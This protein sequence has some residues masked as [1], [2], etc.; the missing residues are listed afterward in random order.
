MDVIS[1][2]YQFYPEIEP[3]EA[4]RI[5]LDGHHEMYWE[6]SGNPEGMPVVFLHGGPGAGASPSHRR[7]FDPNYYRIII[8][9]QRGSGRSRPF[10]EISNNSTQHLIADMERLRDHL[11]VEKWFVFGGSWGSSLALAY[12]INY[13]ERVAGFVLR[14]IFLCRNSELDW[15][16]NGMATVFPES[17]REFN[18]FLPEE[19]RGDVLASFHKRLLN[20]DPSV[21]APA[22]RAWARYEGACST[23]L[24][25][26]RSVPGLKPEPAALALARIEVHYF[27]NRMFMP[28]DYF[29]V[30]LDKIK[31]IPATIIQ[32]RYDMVCPT[33]TADE[34]SR[35]WPEAQ[36]Q[37]IPDAG[38]SAMEP[39]IRSALIAAMEHFKAGY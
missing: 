37:I 31:R 13:P 30:N 8:F 39:S 29:F 24:P 22:A 6:V 36:Y 38:H 11:S 1:S 4:G 7:F 18:H 17:W 26:S 2:P 32:G 27:I 25:N 9:D 28:D 10:A 21:H 20:L 12:G 16:L 23:L 15:F 14:G 3:Y 33:K 35:A 19:E 34:L 5:D